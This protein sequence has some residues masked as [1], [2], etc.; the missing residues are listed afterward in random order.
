[1]INQTPTK[2]VILSALINPQTAGYPLLWKKNSKDSP[3]LAERQ[4][5][6]QRRKI[7]T[8]KEITQ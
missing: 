2:K 7:E 5:Y 3:A 8:D 1:L 6:T 4:G